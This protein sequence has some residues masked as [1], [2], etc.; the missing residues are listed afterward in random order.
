M[1]TDG[2]SAPN[3]TDGEKPRRQARYRRPDRHPARRR[4]A[5]IIPNVGGLLTPAPPSPPRSGPLAVALHVRPAVQSATGVV[6]TSATRGWLDT[7]GGVA[8]VDQGPDGAGPLIWVIPVPE[9]K[10]VKHRMR[11]DVVGYTC[12]LLTCGARR[13]SA[14]GRR[15]RLAGAR[16]PGGQQFCCF[17]PS[18]T[19]PRDA[20]H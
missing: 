12:A 8:G 7:A 4:T 6:T 11:T 5:G 1:K 15:H 16:R 2:T 17:A 3:P 9:P 14:P 20:L 19:S 18:F 13:S 10:T